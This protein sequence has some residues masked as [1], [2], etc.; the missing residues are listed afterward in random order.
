MA[1]LTIRNL[2]ERV[3]TQLRMR[4][5]KHGRSMEE[6]ARRLLSLA[7][8]TPSSAETGLA[9]SIRRRF[10]ALGSVKLEPLPR[11]TMR[12]PPKFK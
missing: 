10:Q 12:A 8:D 11:E 1:S 9:T 2:D 4:A 7:V 6:E 5:A 3:K